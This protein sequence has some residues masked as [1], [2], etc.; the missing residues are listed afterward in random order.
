M[1]PYE[2]FEYISNIVKSE[3]ETE[4][5]QK[6]DDEFY[7]N[8]F[9]IVIDNN[10]ELAKYFLNLL[11]EQLVLLFAI[12]LTKV[13]NG[14]ESK[15]ATKKERY[16]FHKYDEFRRALKMLVATLRQPYASERGSSKMLV[17]FNTQ[18]EPFVDSELN[19]LGPFEKSDMAY[20]P[21]EDALV[22]SR[23][24]IVDVLLGE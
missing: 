11:S 13:I 17:L 2:V 1:K 8:V 16:V 6:L 9:S 22:L 3:F 4:T 7:N 12:R 15:L 23:Y 20:I 5:L 24:G 21:E 19:S 18:L 10:D 14:A